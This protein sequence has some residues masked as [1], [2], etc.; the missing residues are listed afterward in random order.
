[1]E[2]NEIKKTI[3][4]EFKAFAPNPIMKIA[5]EYIM[6]IN[7]PIFWAY[8][9]KP[10]IGK[11]I[12]LVMEFANTGLL[13]EGSEGNKIAKINQATGEITISERI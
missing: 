2:T 5:T 7:E 4:E 12:A 3:E 6:N 10:Y 9:A 1:M 8:E 11:A 13:I